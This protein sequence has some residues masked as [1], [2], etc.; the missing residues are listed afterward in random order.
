MKKSSFVALA[1]AALAF[2][3]TAQTADSVSP[4]HTIT[5]THEVATVT[6]IRYV[7]SA[8]FVAMRGGQSLQI[9]DEAASLARPRVELLRADQYALRQIDRQRPEVTPAW[10]ECPSV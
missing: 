8:G 10:R 1:L 6:A 7:E 2:G 9:A 3:A 5:A 4:R